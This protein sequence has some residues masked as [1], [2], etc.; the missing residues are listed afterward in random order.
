MI[1]KIA[2]VVLL[3][4]VAIGALLV[5]LVALATLRGFEIGLMELSRKRHIDE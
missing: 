3:A 4:I 2:F 5:A 1:L